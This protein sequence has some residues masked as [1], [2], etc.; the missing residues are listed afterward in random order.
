ME[1]RARLSLERSFSGLDEHLA[2]YL[3]C[4]QAHAEPEKQY[5]SA[6]ELIAR[7]CPLRLEH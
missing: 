7:Q 3:I 4:P 5:S 6:R 1:D 2:P